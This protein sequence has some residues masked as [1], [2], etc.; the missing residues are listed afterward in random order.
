[1]D[2]ESKTI[3]VLC[4]CPPRSED[5]LDRVVVA[6]QTYGP[7]QVFLPFERVP[8]EK[9]LNIASAEILS[10]KA[11]VYL[12]PVGFEMAAQMEL[13]DPAPH[14]AHLL[15][16]QVARKLVPGSPRRI[17]LGWTM[18]P[19]KLNNLLARQDLPLWQRTLVESLGA[20][21]PETA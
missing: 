14:P 6:L 19:M 11:L 7:M 10:R 8:K 12:E 2:S 18:F 13:A 20:R 1:M 17:S 21:T 16:R 4:T 5:P 9:D 3:V 15:V